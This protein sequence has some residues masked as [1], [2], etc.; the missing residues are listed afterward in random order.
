MP[1]HRHIS[2]KDPLKAIED[3]AIPNVEGVSLK[4]LQPVFCGAQQLVLPVVFGVGVVGPECVAAADIEETVGSHGPGAIA[5][6]GREGQDVVVKGRD[7]TLKISEELKVVGRTAN[8]SPVLAEAKLLVDPPVGVEDF[9]PA[10]KGDARSELGNIIP[11]GVGEKHLMGEPR[12]GGERGDARVMG[13][14]L[15]VG[16]VE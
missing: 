7:I 5:P 8:E 11:V 2:P 4:K 16:G 10:V 3:V 15:Q 13:D 6:E 12:F 14:G 1:E 9:L